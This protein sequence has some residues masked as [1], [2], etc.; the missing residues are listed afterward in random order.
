MLAPIGIKVTP[1]PQPAAKQFAEVRRA[2]LD[3]YLLG[4]GVTTFDSEYI[5]SL[6]YHTNDN[7]LGGWNGTKFSDPVVDAQ[8]RTLRGEVDQTK[9][10]ATIA[11]LW[12]KLKGEVI[13]VPLHN[14]TITHAMN[15]DFDIPIDVSNQPKM[16]F[17]GFRRN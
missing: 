10:N 1:A 5:F 9:R 16:K 7:G 14:Q 12:R 3:F 13:Y 17:I 6:L 4:W 2:A 15:R 8:I 11:A